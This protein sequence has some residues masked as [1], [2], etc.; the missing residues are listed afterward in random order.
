MIAA[1]NPLQLKALFGFGVALR[2]SETLGT[3]TQG[4]RNC[5]NNRGAK[6]SHIQN[7]IQLFEKGP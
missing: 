7:Q 6:L 5:Q 3:Y 4:M 2:S 1:A